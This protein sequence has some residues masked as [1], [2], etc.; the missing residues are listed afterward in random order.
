MEGNDSIDTDTDSGDL[1]EV[2]I[3]IDDYVL[4]ASDSSSDVLS[5]HND[6]DNL[7]DQV[8]TFLKE[9]Q[10]LIQEQVY[11]KITLIPLYIQQKS[12]IRMTMIRIC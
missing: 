5:E 7:L 4:I 10:T 11:P 3:D 2:E 12:Q 1:V 9:V 6:I 8:I